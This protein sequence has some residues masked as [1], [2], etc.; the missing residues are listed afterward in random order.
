MSRFRPRL[1]CIVAVLVMV[2]TVPAGAQENLDSGKSA[3][4]LFA[5]DC[6]ICHKTPQSLKHAGAPNLVEFLRQHYAA[7]RESATAIAAYLGKGL[8]APA[9]AAKPS[10]KGDGAKASE[11]KPAAAKPSVAKSRDAKSGGA[12][13]GEPKASEPKASEPNSSEPKAGD[14]KPSE[15]KPA[16]GAKPE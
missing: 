10:A 11:K 9:R 6:A 1:P 5:S 4:Q 12:K 2:A 14:A 3:A 13:S 8:A 15:P 7:S 16:D